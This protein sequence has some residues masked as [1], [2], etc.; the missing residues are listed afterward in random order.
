[1]LQFEGDRFSQPFGQLATVT[2]PLQQTFAEQT[3]LELMRT[4]LVRGVLDK[5]FGKGRYRMPGVFL[6]SQMA[7]PVKMI[8]GQAEAS[9]P[10][11]H[12]GIVASRRR[13]DSQS[14]EH[15]ANRS[16]ALHDRGEFLIV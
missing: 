14:E 16:R 6:A 3:P 12:G 15:L 11:L 2:F 5:D 10:A 8:G 7:L 9:D 1:M 13:S 4:A